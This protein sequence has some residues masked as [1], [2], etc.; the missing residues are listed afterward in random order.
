MQ[1]SLSS[2]RWCF[3]P[4]CWVVLHDSFFPSFSGAKRDCAV[5]STQCVS[6]VGIRV[7]FHQ[8]HV[9][10]VCAAVILLV[11]TPSGSPLPLVSLTC[12]VRL[13]IYWF[14]GW[15]W[16]CILY[17]IYCFLS[18][19]VLCMEFEVLQLQAWCFS[20]LSRLIARVSM[21][22]Q[23]EWGGTVGQFDTFCLNY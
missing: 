6:W 17:C 15:C 14:P 4:T 1:I 11:R 3:S 16:K 12:L 8:Y 21:I 10:I 2:P 5:F 22:W 19:Y 20:L 9:L 7:F 18:P 23:R 13:P